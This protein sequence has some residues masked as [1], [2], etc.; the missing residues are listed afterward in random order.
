MA[1]ESIETVPAR[2]DASQNEPEL[3]KLL[4]NEWDGQTGLACPQSAAELGYVEWSKFI[5][6]FLLYSPILPS[7]AHNC[8]YAAGILYRSAIAVS[9][10]CSANVW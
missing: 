1:I 6:S 8:V 10:V 3:C 5:S 7:C 9:L 2:E 4:H